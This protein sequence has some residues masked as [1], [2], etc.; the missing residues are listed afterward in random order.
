MAQDIIESLPGGRRLMKAIAS[1]DISVQELRSL[2]AQHLYMAIQALGL[3]SVPEILLDISPEQYQILLDFELWSRDSFQEEQFFEWLLAIDEEDSFDPIEKLLVSMDIELLSLLISRRVETVAFEEATEESPGPGWYTPDKGNTWVLIK[4]EEPRRHRAFGKLLAYL[5][6]RSAET[7]YQLVLSAGAA[8]PIEIEEQCYQTQR[9]RL[10]DQGIPDHESGWQIHVPLAESVAIKR[11]EAGLAAA[12]KTIESS[13]ELS[14]TSG[15]GLQPFETFIGSLAA[16]DQVQAEI[17][18]LLNAAIV[19]FGIDFSDE[20]G[21]ERV[22]AQVRGAVNIGIERALELSSAPYD[23]LYESLQIK[24]LYQ[25][26]IGLLYGLR[27]QARR[28]SLKDVSDSRLER[29]CELA[30]EPLP[31]CPLFLM[32]EE[33]KYSEDV[34]ASPITSLAQLRRV[35]QYLNGIE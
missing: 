34:S 20:R 22:A 5:F 7:Y 15:V 32:F 18:Q 9:R 10:S 8:T 13:G 25:L 4:I 23:V 12:G 6:Q 17:A 28:V 31:R 24:G 30:K 21:M 16:A 2:P 19:F 11:L 33:E 26:G 35:K 1:G 3:E 29:V 27:T 14:I